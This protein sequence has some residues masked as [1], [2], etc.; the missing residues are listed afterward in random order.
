MK[1][2]V[3]K[4]KPFRFSTEF[5]KKI[6]QAIPHVLPRYS[7]GVVS[8]AFVDNRTIKQFNKK[9]RK[10]DRVTD[11][12]SFPEIKNAGTQSTVG[13]LG[14]IIIAYPYA[15]QQATLHN[16]TITAEISTLLVHG[17]V[18]L[19]GFDH[20]TNQEEQRMVRLERKVLT[21]LGIPYY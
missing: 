13:F 16:K 12:L 2:E 20:R 17:F 7:R 1:F 10:I 15:K 14:E 5:V 11:V 4:T 6:Q 8:V 18:H 3:N 9:Y 19:I 21:R